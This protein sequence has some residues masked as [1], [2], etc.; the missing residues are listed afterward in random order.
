MST[1]PRSVLVASGDRLFG[2]AA[3]RYLE[4]QGWR[5]V[6]I[7]LDGLQALAGL[8]RDDPSAVLILGDLPR[9]A[10]PALAR[11]V[12]RR[13]PGRPV[14]LLGAGPNDDAT[15]LPVDSAGE[16]VVAALAAPPRVTEPTATSQRPNSVALLRSLTSRERLVLKLL[17]EGSTLKD[18]AGRLDV[19]QHT[20]R[21]H[22]QNLYAKLGAHSRLDVVR[23]A[24]E[25]GLVGG[26]TG[27]AAPG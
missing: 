27:E 7:A 19:S 26:E 25:H 16:D 18:V 3:G 11:Q 20:V 24:A 6:G 17:A 1:E 5:V 12:R 13:W 8:A 15:V 22:M 4:E 9:L 10:P 21:T 23:F 2:E 14:V